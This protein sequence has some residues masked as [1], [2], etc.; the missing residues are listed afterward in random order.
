MTPTS[1]PPRLAPPLVLIGL[2]LTGAIAL[3]AARD[4]WYDAA[5]KDEAVLYVRSGTLLQKLALS[6]DLVLA[7]AYWIRTLQHYGG[8]RRSTD[9]HKR[10]DLLYPLLEITT[11]LDPAFSVAYRFGAIF[12]A[13][14]FPDGPGRV[15]Q[16]M[17][18]LRKG[19]AAEPT[20]WQYLQDIGFLYYWYVHD[21]GEAARWFQRASE[22][23]GAPWWLKS[24]AGTTLA[25]GGDRHSSRYLWQQLRET[26]EH[27]WL[28]NT[29]NTRLAQL[30][31]LDQIDDLTRVAI[32]YEQRTGRFPDAWPPLVRDGWLM[33]MPVDP[34]GSAYVLDAPRRTV[35]VSEKSR[36]YP[37]PT[38]R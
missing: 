11:T 37:L 26:A 2:L 3:E 5:R 35:T 13:E 29:A 15:D 9:P 8:T 4:T 16:A 38:E 25:Q 17:A 28:R 19:A 7:D 36:L 24:L 33:R 20:K 14:A 30:D 21:Y 18:L 23:D 31:A 10:Y 27:D 32:R 22:I 12:L 1:S 34:S 6:N